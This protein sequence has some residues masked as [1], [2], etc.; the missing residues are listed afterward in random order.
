[1]ALDNDGLS[2]IQGGASPFDRLPTES[3]LFSV[4]RVRAIV[5]LEV[6]KNSSKEVLWAET[7][8]REKLYN[9]SQVE[10]AVINSANALYNQSALRNSA[11]EIA[12]ALMVEVYDRLTENF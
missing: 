11:E 10:S 1:M 8:T 7:F 5:R 3:A 6:I 4:Y 2:P 12:N 9:S